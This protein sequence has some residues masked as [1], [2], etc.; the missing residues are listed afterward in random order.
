MPSEDMSQIQQALHSQSASAVPTDNAGTSMVSAKIMTTIERVRDRISPVWPLRDYV[1]V[2]PY[3]GFS[4]QGFLQV[5]ETLRTL[6]DLELLM[7]VDYYRSQFQDGEIARTD[8]SN[9]VDELVA[10]GVEGAERIDVNQVIALLR[11]RPTPGPTSDSEF[12]SLGNPDRTLYRFVETLD[13]HTDSDWSRLVEDEISK[14]CATHYDQ[15]QATWRSRGRGLPLYLAW[16]TEKLHDRT[17]EL[18][19]IADFR[20]LVGSLPHQAETAV[21]LLLGL[22]GLPE[23]LWEDYLLCAALAMPGWSSW[24]SYQNREACFAGSESSDF[25]ALLAMQLAYEVAL[26]RHLNFHIDWN[27]LALRHQANRARAKYP[28]DHD[29]LR[30]AL[31]RASEIAWRNRLLGRLRCPLRIKGA[32][33]PS[34]QPFDDTIH[35]TP[36]ATP[37]LA[38]MVFCIDVR[39]ERIRRNLEL[40]A[41]N[42]ETY[43][44]AGFFGLPIEPVELGCQTGV[45]NVPALIEPQFKVHNHIHSDPEGTK[46]ATEKRGAL[47]WMRQAWKEFQTSAISS[48]AFVESTGL[49]FGPK[50]IARTF[51]WNTRSNSRFDGVKRSQQTL[52][53]PSLESLTRQGISLDQQVDL[54]ESILRGIGIT[55]DFGRLVVLCGHACQVENNPLQAGLDCGACGGHSGEPNARLAAKLLN[56][57]KVREG[58]A[59]RGIQLSD[60]THFLAGVHNTT[61]DHIEYFDLDSLPPSHTDDFESVVDATAN[62]TRQTRR[63]RLPLL[64]GPNPNDLDRRSVDWSEVRPEWGLAG[65]AAFIVAPRSRTRGGS[66][67]GRSFLHS[68]D[69]RSDEG[70]GVLEQI[71]TAPMVVA[72]W[73]NLQYYASTVDPLHFGSGNK[74]VHNVVG[75]FGILSGNGGDLMTGLPW[76]SVHDGTQ[77]Q[78]HPM[79]LLSVIEAPCEAIDNVIAKHDTVANLIRHGWLQLVASTETGFYR[80]T[81]IGRWEAVLTHDTNPVDRPVCQDETPTN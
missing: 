2:N 42:I 44:F 45:P 15:G 76:Q 25:A 1:A 18:M 81:E 20:N 12:R 13:R 33:V 6:S 48:F 74:T 56:D 57:T 67:D 28:T 69:Y 70:F 40:A 75:R 51:G 64:P 3:A 31:L 19:G 62:A 5:R 38:Q 9:A 34:F 39:S 60:Q 72:N 36:P 35:S 37:K 49:W 53:A 66:L 7:P 78:H 77:Y 8:I 58:L 52:L 59:G 68:Y 61:T 65:N 32:E 10:D 79:R 46:E 23:C 80:Y 14:Q 50:L 26:S 4:D 73:I 29:L 55:R 17:F 24:T 41:S 27:S 21:E 22:L 16:R 43:G 30:Y 63:D 54:A 71:M 47:R 11:E